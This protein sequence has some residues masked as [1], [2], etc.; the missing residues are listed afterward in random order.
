MKMTLTAY[1]ILLAAALFD[2]CM[3]LRLDI[4]TLQLSEFVNASH[5]K[6]LQATGE[7]TSSKR[8]LVLAVLI[9][10]CTTM[11]RMSWVVVL[12]LAAVILVQAI[13]LSNNNRRREIEIDKRATRLFITTFIFTLLVVEFAGYLGS[14]KGVENAAQDAAAMALLCTAVSPMITMAA[15]W[16]LNPIERRIN[17]E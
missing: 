3:M 2:L 13:G 17:K 11:A 6:K 9:G 12:I 4:L 8:L 15:N 14:Y 10:V 7:F 5:N 16:L 1:I